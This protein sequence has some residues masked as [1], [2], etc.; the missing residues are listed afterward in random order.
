MKKHLRKNKPMS[1]L[2]YAIIFALAAVLIAVLGFGLV[3][4]L[5]FIAKFFF[6]VLLVLALF[7]VLAHI[8]SI[9][10]KKR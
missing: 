8:F 3:G 1:F 10:K 4:I 5:S 7:S 6:Y 2:L 9:V